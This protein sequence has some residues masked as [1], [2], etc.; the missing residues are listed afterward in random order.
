MSKQTRLT[1]EA[2]LARAYEESRDLSEF[3]GDGELHPALRQPLLER[4]A[5]ADVK[6]G[7]GRRRGREGCRRRRGLSTGP[8][9]P[10]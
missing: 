7:I 3:E 8:A 2:A 4:G 1:D 9:V 6:H 5:R 10:E